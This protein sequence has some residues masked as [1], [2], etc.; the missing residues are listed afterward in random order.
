MDDQNTEIPEDEGEPE[1]T[2]RTPVLS[3]YKCPN[4]G[5]GLAVAG[6]V[7]VQVPLTT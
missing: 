4:C 3:Q 6:S 1:K 7:L 5:T 2:P